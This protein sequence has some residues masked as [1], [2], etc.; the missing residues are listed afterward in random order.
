MSSFLQPLQQVF[1]MGFTSQ[2]SCKLFCV[3][4]DTLYE[5]SYLCVCIRQFEH[6]FVFE[7]FFILHLFCKWSPHVILYRSPEF[8]SWCTFVYTS[9][10]T[11]N[12]RLACVIN[13]GHSLCISAEGLFLFFNNN[14]WG[15]GEDSFPPLLSTDSWFVQNIKRKQKLIWYNDLVQ[16]LNFFIKNSRYKNFHLQWKL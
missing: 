14:F 16:L 2:G 10:N 13:Q 6:S 12:S 4:I 15:S 8:G 3:K 7:A 9:S 5:E 1:F 11:D